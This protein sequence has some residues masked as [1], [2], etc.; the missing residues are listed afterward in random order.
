MQALEYIGARRAQICNLI[1]TYPHLT[2]LR[3]CDDMVAGDIPGTVGLDFIV[4]DDPHTNLFEL[5]GLQANLEDLLKVTI[6]LKTPDMLSA[7]SREKI[8]SDAKPL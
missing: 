3:V 2:N 4:D 8:L 6:Y 5:G 7:D 1:K